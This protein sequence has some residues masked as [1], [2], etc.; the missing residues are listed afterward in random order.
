MQMIIEARIVSRTGAEKVISLA[1]IERVDGDLKQLGLNLSEGRVLVQDMQQ[2]LVNAQMHTFVEAS[3]QCPHC[4]AE[5][6]NL[7]KQ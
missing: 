6:S 3:T 2:A 5:L 1:V 7:R 4:R